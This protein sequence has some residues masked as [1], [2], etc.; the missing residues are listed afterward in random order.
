[1]KA[2]WVFGFAMLA[3]FSAHAEVC[4]VM[5]YL[6]SGPVPYG[7]VMRAQAMATDM[8]R[9]IGV[10]VRWRR[11]SSRAPAGDD[12]CVARL[13]VSLS[14]DAR[15]AEASPDAYAYAIPLAGAGTCIHVFMNRITEIRD[16]EFDAILLAHVLVHEITH[17]LQGIS[18]HSAD[19]VMKAHWDL[20]DYERMKSH[21]LLFTA[22]DVAL[23][24]LGIAKRAQHAV[25]E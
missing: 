5:V 23:I 14:P 20:R 1:M 16:R 10:Q 9:E 4:E 21:S 22:E 18:R 7:M 2:H 3:G 19:G 6:S 15:H 12:A 11:G 8:F 17:V 25:A 24:H 13:G